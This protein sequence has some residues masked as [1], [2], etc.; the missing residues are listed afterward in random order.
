MPEL[1]LAHILE[2]MFYD[3]EQNEMHSVNRRLSKGLH[4][5]I[6]QNLDGSAVLSISRDRVYPSDDEWRAVC[7]NLPKGWKNPGPPIL[8][9]VI[10]GRLTLR[11]GLHKM[12]AIQIPLI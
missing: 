7:N 12:E 6:Y 5:S 9:D 11:S 8:K 1:S 3:V 2:D 4:I 10:E